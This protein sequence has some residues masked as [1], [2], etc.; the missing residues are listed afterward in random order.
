MLFPRARACLFP[1]QPVSR[2][3]RKAAFAAYLMPEFSQLIGEWDN[4]RNTYRSFKLKEC[5]DYFGYR[6]PSGKD[7]DCLE[8]CKAI[9]YCY[10]KLI[11]G[12]SEKGGTPNSRRFQSSFNVAPVKLPILATFGAL[13]SAAAL[14]IIALHLLTSVKEDR[15]TREIE[16]S[17]GNAPMYST[18]FSLLADNSLDENGY[19]QHAAYDAGES[20]VPFGPIYAFIPLA[21]GKTYIKNSPTEDAFHRL[22]VYDSS[23]KFLPDAVYNSKLLTIPARDVSVKPCGEISEKAT[24][25]FILASPK[26]VQAREDIDELS[27]QKM[28]KPK[29]YTAISGTLHAGALWNYATGAEIPNKNAYSYVVINSGFTAGETYAFDAYQP[30]RTS[31]YAA[32]VFYDSNNEFIDKVL[33]D[34]NASMVKQE[35]IVP[36]N[37]ASIYITAIKN[38]GPAKMYSIQYS[39]ADIYS[40]AVSNEFAASNWMDRRYQDGEFEQYT[41]KTPDHLVVTFSVDDSYPDISDIATAFN[42]AGVPLCLATIPEYLD[43]VCNNGD[44]VLKVCQ[45]VQSRGGEILTHNNYVLGADSTP[46]QY[47]KYFV[48]SKKA[49]VDA[50]LTVNGII[51]AGGT[52]PGGPPSVPAMLRY[53]RSYYDYGTGFSKVGDGRFTIGRKHLKADTDFDAIKAQI[54]AASTGGI[55]NF[56]THGQVDFPGDNAWVDKIMDLVN[57]ILSKPNAEIVTIGDMFRNNYVK[58]FKATPHRK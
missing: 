53:L 18:Y 16:A 40:M 44:T 56:Y 24:T 42:K 3:K 29:S 27:A 55:R 33:L 32:I 2:K 13:I 12:E 37:T 1:A 43:V 4:T 7:H 10:K 46:E 17:Q 14:I 22:W 38:R 52:E 5:A 39:D 25:A 8:D 45:D 31:K 41:A 30:G 57:Y 9:F 35:V 58:S 20:A 19:Y 47:L 21:A 28:D 11:S 50:G 36:A 34:G 48:T 54:D 15:I 23:N 51:K 6:W 49:L 26:D